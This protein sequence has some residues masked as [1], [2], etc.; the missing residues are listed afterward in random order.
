ME[1][2]RMKGGKADGKNRMKMKER[3]REQRTEGK[4]GQSER[5]KE[6]RTVKIKGMESRRK[7]MT[8]KGR[9]EK[10]GLGEGKKEDRTD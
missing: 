3:K 2:M 9:K 10:K 7:G 4:E 1:G 6:G 5:T 8:V